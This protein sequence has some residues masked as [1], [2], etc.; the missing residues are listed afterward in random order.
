MINFKQFIAEA[1]GKNTHMQDN[2]AYRRQDSYKYVYGIH[3]QNNK[4]N[5]S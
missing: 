2:K 3:I 1:T 5:K 4:S